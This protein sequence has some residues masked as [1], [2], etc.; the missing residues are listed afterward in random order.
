LS[1][2]CLAVL[3]SAIIFAASS[4]ALSASGGPGQGAE[5]I[6]TD[7]V[8]LADESGSQTA[9]SVRQ[10]AEAAQTI[11]EDALNSRSMVAVVGFG[12]NN[13][14]PGQQAARQVCR[15]T[16]IDS[17]PSRQYLADCV[18]GL[19]RRTQA[20]GW[21]T[22][23]AAA[24][25]Q[26]LSYLS[27]NAPANAVKAIFLETDGVLDVHDSPQYGPVSA[28]RN[29][30]ARQVLDQELAQA[31]TAGV[32]IWPLGFGPEVSPSSLAAFAAGGSQKGCVKPYAQVINSASDVVR[33]LDALFASATCQGISPWSTG[34]V[35]GGGNTVLNVGIPVIAT[36]GTITVVKGNPAVRVTYTDPNGVTVSG[37]RFDGSD[38]VLSGTNT[39]VESLHIT[40]PVTGTWKIKLSA[41]AGLGQQLV[42]ATAL[43][44]GAVRAAVFAEPPSATPGQKMVVRLT[45]L[46]RTGA[47]TD[48]SALQGMSFSID[49]TGDGIPG[50]VTVPLNDKGVAPDTKAGDGSFAG[51]FTAPRTPGTLTFTARVSGTGIYPTAIPETVLVSAT[52]PLVEGS[53]SFPPSAFTVSPGGTISGTLTAVNRTGEARP[54]RLILNTQPSTHATI[55]S[56]KGVFSLPSG[57]S[58]QRFTVSFAPNTALGGTSVNL[59]LVDNANPRVVY[60][61]GQLNVDVQKPPGALAKYKWLIVA[62]MVI[63]LAI[64]A[65]L[66]DRRRRRRARRNVRGLQVSLRRDGEQVGAELRAPGRWSDEFRFVIRDPLDQYPRLDYPRPTDQ[67]YVARRGPNGYIRVRAP[68]GERYE[69][70]IG[71]QGEPL[72]NGLLMIFRDKRRRPSVRPQKPAPE[73]TRSSTPAASPAAATPAPPSTTEPEADPWL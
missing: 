30:A 23:F 41:P 14:Q 49:V 15:P 33:S 62:A 16:V 38:F 57:N 55:T 52:A 24:A 63:V 10:E 60:A 43:W 13:G 67:P 25:G 8:V 1:F 59:S 31:R 9:Y 44:Q 12:S 48:G 29:A 6:T 26:A 46:T 19:H 18:G 11:A 27:Q 53:I 20:E 40:D 54:V 7:I 2:F 73:K 61:A 70:A 42:S 72:S 50:P 47:I 17:P 35:T 39:G 4:P 37:G 36:D 45:L 32:G 51:P 28:N 21:D 69:I 66:L 58:T 68:E 71:G 22:D 56:P 65:F 5:P 64:A 34:T 3:S